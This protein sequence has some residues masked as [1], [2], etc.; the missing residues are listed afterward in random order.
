MGWHARTALEER[1]P[2][3]GKDAQVDSKVRGG[4]GPDIA[5]TGGNARL[6]GGGCGKS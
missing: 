3:G 1:E 6:R 4:G 5:K 2:S